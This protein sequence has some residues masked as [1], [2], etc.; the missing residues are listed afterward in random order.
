MELNEIEINFLT[1]AS[2]NGGKLGFV[3]DTAEERMAAKHI[4]EMGLATDEPHGG[5]VHFS[6][7]LTSQGEKK[8]LEEIAKQ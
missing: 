7:K 4:I 3:V 1:E 8:A 5:G 2:K 6:L